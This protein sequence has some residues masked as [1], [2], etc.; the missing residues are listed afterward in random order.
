MDLAI[1]K[2]GVDEIKV[3]NRP[4]LLSDN[5][6]CYISKELKEFM[7]DRELS[8][9]RGQP[10]HPMTQGK[11]ERFHRSM[12]NIINLN[13]CYLPGELEKEIN[14]FVD[15]YNNDRYHESINNLKP[16]DVYN[17]KTYEILDRRE[18]IKR[19]TMNQRRRQ[20]LKK[21]YVNSIC[22]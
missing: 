13:H 4:R 22:I 15:F 17:G 2:T 10:Y 8:H 18:E 21:E 19:R 11:I 9:I 7:R 14:E 5:G 12:K 3:C 16:V 6:P 1:D 20:N